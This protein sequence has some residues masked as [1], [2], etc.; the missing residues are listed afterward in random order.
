LRGF[1]EEAA[2]LLMVAAFATG[3]NAQSSYDRP[4]PGALHFYTA[5]VSDSENDNPV[6]WWVSIEASGNNKAAHGTDYTFISPGYKP[7]TDRLE[8]LP[9]MRCK[10]VGVQTLPTVSNSTS[11]SK[12][13]TKLRVVPT[14]WH[15]P[16]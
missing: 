8:Q 4:W 9:C 16:W 7:A 1:H 10:L 14:E 12:S 15:F 11:F 6:R 13:T 3:W 5:N 2:I